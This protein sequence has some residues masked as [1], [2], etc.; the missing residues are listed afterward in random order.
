MMSGLTEADF[1]QAATT[2][3]VPLAIVQAVAEV[4]SQGQGFLPDGRPVIL[5]E[6][7]IFYKR[8]KQYGLDIAQ[9]TQ[10]CPHIV[11]VSPGGYQ[12]GV[13]EYERLAMAQQIHETAAYEAASWGI[14]QIMGLHWQALGYASIDGFVQCMQRSAREQL[15]AF[16]RYLKHQPTLIHALQTQQWALF[17]RGYNGIDY[18]RH[19]YDLKLAQAWNKY[20]R[21]DVDNC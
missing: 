11:N 3:N 16:I 14:F 8:L 6:R 17:A 10:D 7:H 15:M 2:L 18:A 12:G 13:M 5:F 4:E 1:Q 21:V 9:L 20:M 19:A